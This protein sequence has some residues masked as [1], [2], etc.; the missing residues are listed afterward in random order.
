[1]KIIENKNVLVWQVA[2]VM[3]NIR[4]N[5]AMLDWSPKTGVNICEGKID[6]SLVRLDAR[7]EIFM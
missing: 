2:T 5:A 3:C 1:M 4:E 6:Q 7:D